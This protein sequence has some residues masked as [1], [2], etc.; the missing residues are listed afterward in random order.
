MT[1]ARW[2]RGFLRVRPEEYRLVLIMGFILFFN[3][4]A[5]QVSNIV[6][7]SGF[8]S[9]VSV[10]SILILWVIEMLLIIGSTGVQSLIVDRFHRLQLLRWMSLTFV[11]L[12]VILAIMFAAGSPGWLNYSLLCLFVDQQ[13]YFFP[14][15]YWILAN[16]LTDMSQAKRLFP[17]IA[18]FGV[19]GEIAGLGISAVAP[20]VLGAFS[21]PPSAL[22]YLVILAYMC[23]FALTFLLNNFR[24]RDVLKQDMSV[25]ESLSE[26]INFV[27]EV[28]SFRYLMLSMIS[29]A[30][31]MTI[32]EYHFLASTEAVYNQMDNFQTFYSVIF[33]VQTVVAIVLQAFLTGRIISS[34]GLK[35]TFLI[36]PIC[37]F[38]CVGWALGMPG[39]A[40]G[41][42]AYL[43][44]KLSL[45]SVDDIARKTLQA[46]V[47]EERRGRVSMFMDSYLFASGV[48]ISSI[49]IAI[50]LLTR[51][52]I[53][54]Y[55]PQVIYLVIGAILSIIAL[56]W[57][58]RMR[59]VY[60]SSLFN[61]RLKR[62]QRTA[63]IID[64]LS[65]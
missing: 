52:L 12:Y 17:V 14:A 49:I 18:T 1:I 37:A 19:V 20:G 58:V 8:L 30:I 2:F 39:I 45:N 5:L 40:S 24:T 11:A 22:I 55:P 15:I 36:M 51:H 65:F 62:R 59:K 41:A 50:V 43:V 57:I 54:E 26:G 48:I 27:K 56:W 32:I 46:L 6:S 61:W 31:V 7:I 9:E 63:S 44:A 64:K 25:R 13:L 47:P 3:S 38:L 53:P 42:G 23:P 16:D 33:L 28:P 4:L 60:E 35:N 34:F 29:I 10:D 21:L